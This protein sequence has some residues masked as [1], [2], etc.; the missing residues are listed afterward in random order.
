MKILQ[1]PE[2]LNPLCKEFTPLMATTYCYVGTGYFQPIPTH[3]CPIPF[4]HPLQ[5]DKKRTQG[6]N[7]FTT[8]FPGILVISSYMESL[9]HFKDESEPRTQLVS[10]SSFWSLGRQSHS[11]IKSTENKLL[12]CTSTIFVQFYYGSMPSWI[13]EITKLLTV[14]I[15]NYM[16]FQNQHCTVSIW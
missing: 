10:L 4:T 13:L 7:G 3:Y 8:T 6:G 14:K 1:K 16:V 11:G 5:E 2:I 15:K 9:T 12:H